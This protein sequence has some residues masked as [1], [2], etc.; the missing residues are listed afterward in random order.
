VAP[1]D[2]VGPAISLYIFTK[3]VLDIP[4][5]KDDVIP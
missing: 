3:N 5:G 2:P 4:N 1:V